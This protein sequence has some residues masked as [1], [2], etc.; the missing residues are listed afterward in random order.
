MED[1]LAKRLQGAQ[2][3][4]SSGV[5]KEFSVSRGG[6]SGGTGRGKNMHTD[7][8]VGKAFLERQ[9]VP[10]APLQRV[11]PEDK[12]AQGRHAAEGPVVKPRAHALQV[13]KRKW[14]LPQSNRGGS[15]ENTH[16]PAIIRPIK[17]GETI[18]GL[19]WKQKEQVRGCFRDLSENRIL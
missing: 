19:M 17:C 12:G 16:G 10:L 1:S 8:E 3:E 2:L 14:A 6:Q 15:K 5:E 11:S 9:G 4:V 18:T 13:M 7:G